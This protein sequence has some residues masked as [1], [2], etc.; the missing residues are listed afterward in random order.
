MMKLGEGA[1]A[2]VFATRAFGR[3]VV[4]KVRQEK[5][6]RIC[7]LDLSLRLSRTRREARLMRRARAAG[8]GAPRIIALGKFSIYMERLS[9]K[10]LKDCVVRRSEYGRVGALLAGMHNAGMVHGDFTPANVMVCEGGLRVIDFGLAEES[11]SAEERAIDLLLMKRSVS[12]DCY[13]KFRRGY[14]EKA[15]GAREALRRLSEVEKR[16]RYQVRTLL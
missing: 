3:D 8:A 12:E 4:V 10:L 1:E 2:K 16:G 14:A 7:E 6:Y 9:G 13:E 11:D 5:K 15:D